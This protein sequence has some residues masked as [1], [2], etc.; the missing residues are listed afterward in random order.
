M[1]RRRSKAM[2]L[3]TKLLV[4]LAM[5]T[6]VLFVAWTVSSDQTPQSKEAKP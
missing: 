4:A 1:N 2:P 6:T 5:T 3:S